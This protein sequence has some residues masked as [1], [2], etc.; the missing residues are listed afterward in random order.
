MDQLFKR[1]S[2]RNEP[3]NNEKDFFSF[4]VDDDQFASQGRILQS[5]VQDRPDPYKQLRENLS[6][7]N[8]D[9]NY[10]LAA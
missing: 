7:K 8:R 1:K 9:L 5:I 3:L 6:S 10:E 4:N 2:S